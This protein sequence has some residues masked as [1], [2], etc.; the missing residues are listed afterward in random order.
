MNDPNGKLNI[1]HHAGFWLRDEKQKLTKAFMHICWD[2]CMFPNEVMK[3]QETWNNILR[4]MIAVRD[5]HGW[6]DLG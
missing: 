4:S 3:K 6:N 1:P 2:G 5:Q